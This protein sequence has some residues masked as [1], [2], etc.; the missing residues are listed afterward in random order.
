MAFIKIE[1][2]FIVFDFFGQFIADY[3]SLEENPESEF[4]IKFKKIEYEVLE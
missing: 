2:E 4:V 3:Q 1:N